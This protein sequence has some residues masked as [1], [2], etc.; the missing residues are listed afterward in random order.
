MNQGRN[1]R[2]TQARAGYRLGSE[3]ITCRWASICDVVSRRQQRHPAIAPKCCMQGGGA[4][5]LTPHFL[6]FVSTKFCCRLPTPG[7]KVNEILSGDVQVTGGSSERQ[8]LQELV[9]SLPLPLSAEGG[10]LC[11]HLQPHE[12]L[13]P[14][15]AAPS[16]LAGEA[17]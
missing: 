1:L 12:L 2:H 10:A 11:F 17:V 15:A 13:P 8:R 14:G 5:L 4:K 6:L 9:Q 3:S 7:C 16:R